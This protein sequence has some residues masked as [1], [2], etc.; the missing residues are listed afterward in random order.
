MSSMNSSLKF[1]REIRLI[2]ILQR[3]SIRKYS[4]SRF[5]WTLTLTFCQHWIIWSWIG[6]LTWWWNFSCRSKIHRLISSFILF[7]FLLRIGS[8][9]T[10]FSWGRRWNRQFSM[11]WFSWLTRHCSENVQIFYVYTSKIESVGSTNNRFQDRM[12]RLVDVF[13]CCMFRL[14]LRSLLSK[15]EWI[16]SSETTFNRYDTIRSRRIH[17]FSSMNIYSI[18]IQQT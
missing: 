2:N 18:N 4:L 7:R 5:W 13:F 8:L 3:H 15:T 9:L 16:S 6:Q 12:K 14:F 10:H 1:N 17:S 11:C